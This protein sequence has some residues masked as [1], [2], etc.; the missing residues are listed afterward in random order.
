MPAPPQVQ[1][2]PEVSAQRAEHTA[3][4]DVRPDEAAQVILEIMERLGAAGWKVPTSNVP[5]LWDPELVRGASNEPPRGA[6]SVHPPWKPATSM[7]P[8]MWSAKRN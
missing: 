6:D 4:D 3:C 2:V 7:L 8:S 5:M 1:P